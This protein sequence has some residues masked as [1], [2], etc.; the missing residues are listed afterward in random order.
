MK[1]P[2]G[3]AAQS[4]VRSPPGTSKGWLVKLQ[5]QNTPLA[6]ALA[7]PQ[8]PNLQQSASNSWRIHTV[9]KISKLVVY[10]QY[11]LFSQNMRDVDADYEGHYGAAGLQSAWK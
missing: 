11:V 10:A 9:A 8:R 2:G 3:I 5:H 4:I 1:W 6:S 7:M